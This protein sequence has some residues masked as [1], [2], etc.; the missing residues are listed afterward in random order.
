MRGSQGISGIGYRGMGITDMMPF[1]YNLAAF[2]LFALS[3][4]VMAVC[5]SFLCFK[6]R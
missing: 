2:V 6:G 5:V 1:A 3:W 4:V